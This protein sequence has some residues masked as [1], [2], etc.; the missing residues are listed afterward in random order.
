MFLI[1]SIP[2][3]SPSLNLLQYNYTYFF[4]LYLFVQWLSHPEERKH[5]MHKDYV[6]FQS[7][8]IWHL[9]H[10]RYSTNISGMN[11]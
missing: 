9:T 2:C 7:E 3:P 6:D 5:H 4:L 1:P 10:R 11:D 8:I